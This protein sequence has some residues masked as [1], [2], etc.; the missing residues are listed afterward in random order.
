LVADTQAEGVI[1]NPRL[2][3]TLKRGCA[4]KLNRGAAFFRRVLLVSI[5][6]ALANARFCVPEY[7]CVQSLGGELVLLNVNTGYYFGLDEQGKAFFEA[8]TSGP[9]LGEALE[10]LHEQYDVSPEQ[11]TADFLELSDKLRQHGLVVN[12]AEA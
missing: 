5:D 9:T 4:G 7:V 10:G 2:L 8:L 3:L 1:D 12:A 6:A 11:L